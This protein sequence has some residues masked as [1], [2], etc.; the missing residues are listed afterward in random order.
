MNIK[1][2]LTVLLLVFSGLAHAKSVY[3]TD[4]MTFNIN[5]EDTET[6]AILTTVT[7]GTPLVLLSKKRSSEY[8]KVR[9]STGQVGFILNAYLV[10]QPASRW[11][12]TKTTEELSK[13]KQEHAKT[14]QELAGI[15]KRGV[16]AI[17][18]A[19]TRERDKLSA[20]LNQLR[21]ISADAVEVKRD[22]DALQENFIRVN[23]ELEQIKLEKKTLET[24]ASQ[25]WFIYG[26]ALSLLSVLLGYILPILSFRRKS[27]NW[28]TL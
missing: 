12:L 17:T 10:P 3:V 19:L 25:D 20:E 23:K 2:T 11:Y 5:V 1:K 27:H 22:R 7:S 24:N 8:A 28:D 16:T 9:L 13:L 15:K 14:E 21:T 4:N 18:E 6:S 26:G